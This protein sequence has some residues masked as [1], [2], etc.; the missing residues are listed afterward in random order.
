MN[1]MMINDTNTNT[2]D[3]IDQINHSNNKNDDAT[4]SNNKNIIIHHP[5]KP[6]NQTLLSAIQLPRFH[7]FNLIGFFLD[8]IQTRGNDRIFIRQPQGDEIAQISVP[9]SFSFPPRESLVKVTHLFFD[10]RFIRSQQ[11]TQIIAVSNI[12]PFPAIRNT[13][14]FVPSIFAW[15]QIAVQSVLSIRV[16]SLVDE[17]PTLATEAT[18]SGMWGCQRIRGIVRGPAVWKLLRVP[19]NTVARIEEMAGK[20]GWWGQWRGSSLRQQLEGKEWERREK[21]VLREQMEGSMEEEMEGIRTPRKQA[22]EGARFLWEDPEFI[23]AEGGMTIVDMDRSIGDVMMLTCVG[24]VTNR[25]CKPQRREQ[26]TKQTRWKET[27]E[28]ILIYEVD[29]PLFID[30]ID[31]KW[32]DPASQL[33]ELLSSTVF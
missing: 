18:F 8:V 13:I 17:T 9:P 27:P 1:G 15:R 29:N 23:G 30:V 24:H 22:P 10:G 14:P 16:V 12:P 2:N 5:T 26:K 20:R 32:E 31:V 11:N 6:T 25:L 21:E 19:R 7:P 33:F 3:S 4:V 28:V